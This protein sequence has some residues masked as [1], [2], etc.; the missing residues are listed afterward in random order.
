[1]GY[2]WELGYMSLDEMEEVKIHGLGIERDLYFTPKKLH[3]IAELEEIVQ[4]QYTKEA[5]TQPPRTGGGEKP[6]IER[7]KEEIFQASPS[8]VPPLAGGVCQTTK[9]QEQVSWGTCRAGS[10]C[11]RRW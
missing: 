8:G 6:S 9:Q 10:E 5:A 3:E 2:G 4:G 1:M 7:Q 11:G